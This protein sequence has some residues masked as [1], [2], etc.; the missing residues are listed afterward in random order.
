MWSSQNQEGVSES[1]VRP[2]LRLGAEQ[3]VHSQAEVWARENL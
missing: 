1:R 2:S 3:P